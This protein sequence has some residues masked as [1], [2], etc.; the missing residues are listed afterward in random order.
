MPDVIGC[1]TGNA[2]QPNGVLAMARPDLNFKIRDEVKVDIDF[3]R[4]QGVISLM[5]ND[6]RSL[7]LEAGYQTLN[8]IHEEIRAKMETL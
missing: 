7:Q 6:G 4:K 3:E 5:T 8:K 1:A 2:K